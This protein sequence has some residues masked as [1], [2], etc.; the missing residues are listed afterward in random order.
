MKLSSTA[1]PL[2][3]LHVQISKLEN[4]IS[5]RSGG[6]GSS[7]VVEDGRR[8][9]GRE[10]MEDPSSLVAMQQIEYRERERERERDDRGLR[11]W[12]EGTG[13]RSAGVGDHGE[14]AEARGDSV[15]EVGRGWEEVRRGGLRSGSQ[16]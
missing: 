13:A 3:R 10:G 8:G 14:A 16:G 4:Q 2:W 1:A 6:D 5:G 11:G 7:M 12:G 9:Q 15:G